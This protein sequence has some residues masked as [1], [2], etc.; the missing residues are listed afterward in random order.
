MVLMSDILET[1]VCALETYEP[2]YIVRLASFF[3]ML[4]S[5]G[6]PGAA[7]DAVAAVEPFPVGR[8]DLEPHYTW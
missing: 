3:F 2:S 4:E 6:P 7:G 5:C 8:Q 1:C